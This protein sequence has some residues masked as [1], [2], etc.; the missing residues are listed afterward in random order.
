M[1]L[2]THSITATEGRARS[3]H[4]QTLHGSFDTP[5]F[6]PVGT[7]GSVKGLDVQ[8]LSE[9]GAQILLVNLSDLV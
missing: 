2:N 8:R 5:N 9:L 1:S 6:M 7:R 4:Y 3:G